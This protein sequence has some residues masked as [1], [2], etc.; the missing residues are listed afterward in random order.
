[1][2]TFVIGNVHGCCE[3]LNNLLGKI[4]PDLKRDRLVMLGDYIDRGPDSCGVLHTIVKLQQD[5]G[6]EH[7]VL[8]RGNHEQ[9]AV[10]F[11]P[12]GDTVFSG[13]EGKKL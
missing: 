3:E 1:M 6:K 2:K 13:T 12:R 11:F 10:D 5:F 9:M 8:L 4:E 7:V